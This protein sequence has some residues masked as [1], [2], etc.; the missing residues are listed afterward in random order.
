MLATESRPLEAKAD[1]DRR[2]TVSVM[3][4]GFGPC[5]D[6]TQGGQAWDES[7][8]VDPADNQTTLLSEYYCDIT[9]TCLT[10]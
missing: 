5:R 9:I 2:A 10:Q 1:S 8:A 7:T 6:D 3:T 4:P